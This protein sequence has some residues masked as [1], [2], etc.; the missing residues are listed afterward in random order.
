MCVPAH[1]NNVCKIER[2]KSMSSD[3][4][5]G[6]SDN[7]SAAPLHGS[8]STAKEYSHYSCDNSMKPSRTI[9]VNCKASASCTIKHATNIVSYLASNYTCELCGRAE[10][11][12]RCNLCGKPL[13]ETLFAIVVHISE[14]YYGG[15]AIAKGSSFIKS[16]QI[17]TKLAL[18]C[19][20]TLIQSHTG[21]T[22][23]PDPTRNPF[24]VFVAGSEGLFHKLPQSLCLRMNYDLMT[25]EDIRK[26]VTVDYTSNTTVIIVNHDTDMYLTFLNRLIEQNVSCI[27][28]GMYFDSFPTV[29]TIIRHINDNCVSRQNE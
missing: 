9:N 27:I 11:W 16:G 1:V 25:I 13:S 3:G 22:L 14:C 12:V 10:W 28:C 20:I 18:N 2:Q 24:I 5:G 7:D 26:K 15:R 19:A 8:A 29:E 4:R 17:D 23:I 21:N 6:M